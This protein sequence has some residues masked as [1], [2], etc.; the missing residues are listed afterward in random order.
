MGRCGWPLGTTS[1]RL[2]AP[3]A[4]VRCMQSPS[5]LSRRMHVRY[6]WCARDATVRCIQSPPHLARA[7]MSVTGAMHMLDVGMSYAYEGR[8]AAWRCRVDEHGA[9]EVCAPCHPFSSPFIIAHPSSSLSSFHILPHPS[10]SFHIPPRPSS[11]LRTPSLQSHP[12]PHLQSHLHAISGARPV[13]GR[14][15]G[16]SRPVRGVRRDPTP[17]GTPAA[18]RGRARRLRQLLRGDQT[19][20]E[21]PLTRAG[22]VC[23][24]TCTP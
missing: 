22:Y 21:R 19:R 10:T 5:H 24:V 20:Q 3:D 4:K 8:P 15:G 11:P 18:R 6:R 1:C 2:W 16:A 12:Q 13:R 17:R 7:C 9:S 23:R 14:R